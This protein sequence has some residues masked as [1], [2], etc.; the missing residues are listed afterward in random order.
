M[1]DRQEIA[2]FSQCGR[3]GTRYAFPVMLDL[4]G[5][6]TLQKAALLG[7]CVRLPVSVDTGRLK[8]EVS[9]LPAAEWGSPGGRVGV[10]RAA[11]AI[12]LRGF[13][14]AE[15]DRPIE[16][17]AP[18]EAL[19]TIR[20]FIE[21]ALGGL[22]QRCLLARL[23][24]GAVITTHVDQ[25]PYFS[26]TLRIHVPI[27]THDAVHMVCAA[28]VYRMAE[29][30]VWVLDNSSAHAV[31]NADPARPRTHLICD[32]VPDARLLALVANG[33]RGLGRHD[34]DVL[35]RVSPLAA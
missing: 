7:G 6:P 26:K 34:P 31:W 4:P 15:G 10:H 5:V 21:S 12:W 1:R 3:T 13:A 9:R 18:L 33:E 8:D 23:P 14:P 24:A 17:R 28:R 20:A 25:A 11:E 19:P 29:G 30:E 27:D 16:D 2:K 35:R 32:Y 22:A